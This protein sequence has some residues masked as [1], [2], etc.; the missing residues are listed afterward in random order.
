LPLR[1]R[2]QRP[3]L[4][5]GFSLSE[6][7]IAT[8]ILGV[9]LTMVMAVFPAAL[10]TNKDSTD[11]TLG[12]IIC[13]NGL[14]V[15]KAELTHPLSPVS[16]SLQPGTGVAVGAGDRT[17]PT[18]DA[19]RLRGFLALVRQ[20]TSGQNDYQFVIISYLKAST[21]STVQAVALGATVEANAITF[22]A[23]SAANLRLGSPVIDPL[24]GAYAKI[25][26]F[27]GTIVTLDHPI[28]I[29]RGTAP[30]SNPLVIVETGSGGPLGPANHV[31]VARAAL[32]QP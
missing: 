18:G 8:A 6:I 1:E 7:L 25:V 4:R 15:M 31:L 3:R 16:S 29:A 30:I 10:D 11:D 32:R 26:S 27:A 17:F 5:G 2:G 12:T 23:G 22:N 20:V 24:T 21:A 28:D 19:N 13:E 14:S 9:G